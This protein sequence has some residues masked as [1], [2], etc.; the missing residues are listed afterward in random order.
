MTDQKFFRGA[1]VQDLNFERN[2]ERN[3]WT[4]CGRLIRN[5]C[6]L[7]TFC[8]CNSLFLHFPTYTALPFCQKTGSLGCRGGQYNRIYRTH[9]LREVIKRERE[10]INKVIPTTERVLLVLLLRRAPP[11]KTFLHELSASP[12]FQPLYQSILFF[13]ETAHQHTT[14][15]ITPWSKILL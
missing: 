4:F 12:V 13:I 8:P 15:G 10:K 2:Q 3:P 11:K 5:W 1:A 14:N 6:F 9:P 7:P